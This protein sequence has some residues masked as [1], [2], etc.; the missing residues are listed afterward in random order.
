MT[1]KALLSNNLYRYKQVFN[2]IF[3]QY[4]LGRT[5]EEVTKIDCKFL[6]LWTMIT[7]CGEPTENIRGKIFITKIKDDLQDPPEEI[8]DVAF[9]NYQTE[10]L[11]VIDF[12]P[13]ESL[14]NLSIK[15]PPELT[16]LEIISNIMYEVYLFGVADEY[17]IK[18]QKNRKKAWQELEKDF[19][20]IY[21]SGDDKPL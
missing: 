17:L 9:F 7:S 19:K 18:R 6:E 13:I 2:L 5:E 8:I 4:L 10:S 12:I 14:V 15:S 11:E 20:D 21:N 1:L 16:E 3:K